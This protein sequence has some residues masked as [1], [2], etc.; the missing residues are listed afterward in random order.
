MTEP[1]APERAASVPL[2]RTPSEPALSP[3]DAAR[4]AMRLLTQ[5][6]TC[7]TPEAYRR[8]WET[9]GGPTDGDATRS[10]VAALRAERRQAARLRKVNAELVEI[11]TALCDCLSAVA[12]AGSG[13]HPQVEA[14]RAA[15]REPADR[16][17]L[18][19]ARSLLQQ[20]GAAHRSIASTRRDSVAELRGLLPHLVAQMTDLGAGASRFGDTLSGHL[21]AISQADSLDGVAERVRTML[22]DAHAVR[23][24]ID[25]VGRDLDTRTER[26]R[27]LEA[28]V[29]RLETELAQASE[30]A[31]TD[32]LTRASNRAGLQQAYTRAIAAL[33][34]G[35]G[36]VALALLD[37]DDFKKVNDVRGHAAGDG[38][39]R[40]LA[41]LLKARIGEA[42]TV[43]RYGGEE[44]VILMPE[45]S[46][47]QTHELL[48]RVQREM[49]REVYMH[50]SSH[51]F[52][53]FS[54]G[55]TAV[56]DD[57]ALETA[58]ARADDAMYRAKDAG[59]NRVEMG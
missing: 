11:A 7:P 56:R 31:L 9:V 48:L 32:H 58:V 46:V 27:V 17:G 15:L 57:E 23:Q 55:V 59:K 44:F 18:A 19:A 28:E 52:V 34:A 3:L 30:R 43:A 13:V 22:D 21:E 26:A 38:V 47:A 42:A 12:D 2:Q 45:A 1:L 24:T 49:T 37:I 36:P 39:L 14:V 53:T 5:E 8:A 35:A 6:R 25:A 41:E 54:A 29:A 4:A 50:E 20:G 51:V 10:N 40:H 33:H 16:R